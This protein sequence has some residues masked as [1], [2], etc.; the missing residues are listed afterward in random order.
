[1][2]PG[3]YAFSTF[4]R[5]PGLNLGWFIHLPCEL[6]GGDDAA[7]DERLRERHGP[8][9]VVAHRIVGLRRQRLDR[10]A[11]LVHRENFLH[12]QDDRQ[13]ID[14]PLPVGITAGFV[15]L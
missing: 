9:L 15:V 14:A 5:S 11:A 7:L 12:S 4:T 6:F 1:M 2:C 8:A 3:G 13:R 10:A